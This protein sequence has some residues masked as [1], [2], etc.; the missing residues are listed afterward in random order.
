[1]LY[2]GLQNRYAESSDNKDT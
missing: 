1:M 2:H